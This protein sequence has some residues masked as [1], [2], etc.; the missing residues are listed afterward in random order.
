[1]NHEYEYAIILLF[2][3]A[4]GMCQQQRNTGR[5]HSAEAYHGFS[6]ATKPLIRP[7][8]VGYLPVV[9]TCNSIY[10]VSSK[11]IC[12]QRLSH[13]EDRQ[14]PQG[15]QEPTMAKKSIDRSRSQPYINNTL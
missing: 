8:Y 13:A 6:F 4:D 10:E 1:M 15:E 2:F 5:Y 9:R 14:T 12:G 11:I 7:L 3:C